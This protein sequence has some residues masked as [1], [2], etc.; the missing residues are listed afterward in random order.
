M[1]LQLFYFTPEDEIN[2]FL[3]NVA[4]DLR[5]YTAPQPKQDMKMAV[6]PRIFPWFHEIKGVKS[7]EGFSFLRAGMGLH[8]TALPCYSVSDEPIIEISHHSRREGTPRSTRVQGS[9]SR[10]F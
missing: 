6:C 1:S 9:R 4:I 2:M 3:R 5:S 8:A 10:C 7:K